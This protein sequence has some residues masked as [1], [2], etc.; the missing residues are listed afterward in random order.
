[1]NWVRGFL[2][3][4]CRFF[5]LASVCTFIHPPKVHIHTQSIAHFGMPSVA[6]LSCVRIFGVCYSVR[7]FWAIAEFTYLS[8]VSEFMVYCFIIIIGGFMFFFA[9]TF[10]FALWPTIQCVPTHMM[11]WLSISHNKKLKI[12]S[13]NGIV[14]CVCGLRVSSFQL[15]QRSCMLHVAGH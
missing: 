4:W 3:N 2:Q 12:M 1:M 6:L 15:P 9:N 7:I 8:V 13:L 5:P 14:M 10:L 11:D